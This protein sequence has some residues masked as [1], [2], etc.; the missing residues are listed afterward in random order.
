M[1]MRKSHVFVLVTLLLLL[2]GALTVTAHAT[3][4]FV[5]N[6]ADSTILLRY[7][8]D[9]TA[10]ITIPNTFKTVGA[11]AFM[12]NTSIQSVTIPSSVTSM[13]ADAFANCTA[14]TTVNLSTNL[15]G[16]PARAFKNC[17]ALTQI[18]LPRSVTFISDQAFYG[19]VAMHHVY[20]PDQAIQGGVTYW[21]VS[22]YVTSIGADAFG[23][24]PKVTIQC[25]SGSAMATYCT[26]NNLSRAIVDPIVYGIKATRSPFVIIYDPSNSAQVQLTVTV[27]PSFV[28]TDV[29]G[30]SSGN[31]AI[32][33]VSATGLLTPIAPGTCMSTVYEQKNVN[34]YVEIP[35]VVL[36]D[37][38][39]WQ[40]WTWTQPG[41]GAVTSWFYC[42]SRTEFAIGWQLINGVWYHFNTA[43]VMDT[44]WI[45]D[46]G[47]WYYLNPATGAMATGWLNLPAGSN[48]WFYLGGNG[49]MVT[50]WIKLNN[51]WFYL[52][53]VAANGFVQGQMYYGGTYP[54]GGTNYL[55]DNN[56]VLISDSG[57][58]KV[59]N[60]WYYYQGATLVKGW[61][62]WK[63]EWY[64]LDATTGAMYADQW[65]L[66]NGKYYYLSG[67][68]AMVTGWKLIGGQW[69]YFDKNGAMVMGWL[70]YKNCWY[71]LSK[72]TGMEGMMLADSW[73]QDGYWYYLKPDGVMATGWQKIGGYWYYFNKSGA[74]VTNSWLQD[75]AAWYYLQAD[76]TMA[77]GSVN[78]NGTIYN[79][80]GNGVWI[81]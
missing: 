14:L 63:N 80:D 73:V 48:T 21:P 20:G 53:P 19:C 49:A 11:Q 66:Y 25:F 5:P 46:G 50:G 56:G 18:T 58:Q 15:D 79:F 35:L 72:T 70:K 44:G 17:S 76:G 10:N 12:G 32:A 8:D 23:N 71:Y 78:I 74:L 33:K 81:N 64:Y 57:W 68:G 59:G 39:G 34:T 30:Y 3:G 24:C 36:D 60:V 41:G 22:A 42:K 52:A 31:A 27:D 4:T 13:G 75:G 40:Q 61:L 45:Q 9:G 43:G 38:L 29:L 26:D 69:Y 6:P 16:I 67:S 28:S 65:V 47:N 62:Q 7:D 37:R 77:T 55:F 54:I 51:K 2:V 1:K